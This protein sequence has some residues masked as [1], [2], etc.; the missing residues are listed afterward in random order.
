MLQFIDENIYSL[1][2]KM[3]RRVLWAFQHSFDENRNM[4]DPQ[5]HCTLYNGAS[6]FI[7]TRDQQPMQI[8]KLTF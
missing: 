1:Q 5:S 6:N 3:K 2:I 7:N 4:R 8:T